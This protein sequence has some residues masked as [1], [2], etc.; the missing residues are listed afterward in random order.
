MRF[1]FVPESRPL[2]GYTIKRAIHRGGFGEVYYALSD[3]GKEVALKLLHNNM[4]VELRG[5]SQCL[6]LK[7][8]NL[9]TIFDIRQD[10]EQE[11]WI[12]MEYVGGQSLYD[13]LCKHPSGM[14]LPEIL[15]WLDGMTAGLSFLHDRGLVHRDLKPANIFSDAGIV[16]IGDVGLSKYISDSRRSAQTQ[17]VGTVY[18]M[19][20]EVARGRYGREVDVYSMG[21]M[22]C[23]MM[24]GHVPFEGETT[25]EILMKHLTAEPDLTRLPSAVRTVLAAAL[26]KDPARRIPSVDLLRQRF[27]QA[28]TNPQSAN[29]PQGPATPPPRPPQTHVDNSAA[30]SSSR[31]AGEI[32]PAQLTTMAQLQQYFDDRIP[33]SVKWMLSIA[34]LTLLVNS[35]TTGPRN[36]IPE[37]L[38]ISIILGA[39]GAWLLPSAKS[40]LRTAVDHMRSRGPATSN[41]QPVIASSDP[42]VPARGQATPQRPTASPVILRNASPTT[43]RII[44][45]S[46]RL[47]TMTSSMALSLFS[48]LV[49]SLLLYFATPVLPSE[50]DG[51]FFAIA[52]LLVTWAVIIPSRLIEGT[53]IEPWYRR[54]IL[55]GCGA[56][57][58]LAVGRM[59]RFLMLEESTMLKSSGRG[60]LERLSSLS[61]ET[62]TP[63]V[64]GFV[65]FLALLF[66]VR[67]WWWQADSFR[68]QRLR[69]ASSLATAI[70]AML[71]ARLT[72]FPVTF[73]GTLALAVSV[74]VQ[75][76]SA[77]TPSDQRFLSTS[78]AEPGTRR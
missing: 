28:V 23:E 35:G 76:S 42:A 52:T 29:L 61:T 21:I 22:L 58:G 27:V 74:V 75:L 71:L 77:W 48:V 64:A 44:P 12:V 70:I 56:L 11:H 25:A 13:V 57:A 17:S 49:V 67:R 39:L 5:V 36:T 6:N 66:F 54:I 78:A 55:G 59:A 8:P 40:R 43:L 24:T 2:E 19:A 72:A 69:I 65:I 20:P 16:K 18:Y 41:I 62:N 60:Y 37:I 15:K 33:Y 7:H 38:V 32:P 31:P 50:A 47:V 53:R 68:K 45:L 26:E 73:A 3:A 46:Q 63:T 4:E 10:S 1:T 30:M 9:V 51:L 34:F 14:P